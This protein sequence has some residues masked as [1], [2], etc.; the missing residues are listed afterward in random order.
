MRSSF[1][2]T[3]SQPLSVPKSSYNGVRSC[4]ECAPDFN[5]NDKLCDYGNFNSTYSKY[6]Y[7]KQY[8][9]KNIVL[10]EVISKMVLLAGKRSLEIYLIHGLVLAILKTRNAVIFPSAL[11]YALIFT[12]FLIT[13]AACYFIIDV[14]SCNEVLRKSMAIRP[15]I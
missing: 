2:R 9:S 11:G 3:L 12:N 14:I 8:S 4:G 10:Y 15:S 5:D 7:E 1:T 13:L 6:L